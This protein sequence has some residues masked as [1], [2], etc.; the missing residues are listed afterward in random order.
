MSFVSEKTSKTRGCSIW[1]TYGSLR[2]PCLPKYVSQ[3]FSLLPPNPCPPLLFSPKWEG[4]AGSGYL[5]RPAS[6]EGVGGCAEALREGL[7]S[8]ARPGR[9]FDH[10][11]PAGRAW[12]RRD[13]PGPTA[14]AAQSRLFPLQRL[15]AAFGIIP[16]KAHF[17]VLK[18]FLWSRYTGCIPRP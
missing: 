18:W 12:E 2:R 9:D 4:A 11:Q 3:Y 16:A 5:G 1:S 7:R 13:A 10:A 15:C 14:A 17:P 8:S 6:G